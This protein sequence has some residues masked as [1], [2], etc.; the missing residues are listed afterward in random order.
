MKIPVYV[1]TGFL[2]SGKTT[3]LNRLVSFGMSRGMKKLVLQFETGEMGLNCPPGCRTLSFSKWEL[4][5]KPDEI[6]RTVRRYLSE[7]AVDE[8][9]VEWNGMTPISALQEL[10][11]ARPLDGF[12]NIE[13]VMHV[14]EAETF[15]EILGRTGEALP[16]QIVNSDFAIARSL[17]PGANIE[18]EKTLLRSLN[19]GIKVFEIHELKPIY[20]ASYKN[21]LDPAKVLYLGLFFLTMAYLIAYSLVDLSASPLNTMI[22]V[23][24]GIIL[25]AIPFLIIGVMISSAIQIFVPNEIIERKMPKSLGQGMLFAILLGFC[26]PVCDCASVPVFRS[27][28]K[29]G[30]PLPVAVTFL[31]ASP[32]INPVVILSTFYAFGGNIRITALRV[33][34]GVLSSVMIGLI[35]TLRRSGE[36]LRVLGY[37]GATCSCGCLLGAPPSKGIIGK[38]ELFVRHSRT[39]FFE[40][41]KYLVLGALFSAL[42]QVSGIGSLLSQSG[43]GFPLSL[44]LMMLI[45]FLLSLCSSSDAIIARSLSPYFSAGAYMGFLLFGP[46][47]DLKNLFM[48]SGSFSKKFTLKLL[49][50]TFAVCYIIVFLVAR[51]FLGV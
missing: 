20:F 5:G 2:G 43:T 18:S 23:F 45:A 26:L 37:E 30:V 13:R 31:C 28:V 24:L 7:D 46:M 19:P 47:M 50:A 14:F 10:L 17:Y 29:K 34:L 6:S 22:N 11:D 49:A 1:V 16:E 12:C 15:E 48:L 42:F 51:Y 44:F 40:V 9:W 27:L 3:L 21:R 4:D 35:F 32:V 36:K 38:A 33:G 41:G 8:I 39:E 25:Q